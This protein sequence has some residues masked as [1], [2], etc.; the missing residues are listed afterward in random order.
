MRMNEPNEP[1]FAVQRRS[2]YR[3]E[4]VYWELDLLSD[5]DPDSDTLQPSEVN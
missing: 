2:G 4:T 3:N 5:A 1:S